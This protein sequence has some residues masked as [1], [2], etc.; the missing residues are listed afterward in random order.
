[1]DGVDHVDDGGGHLT[2][3]G[4][5][6]ACGDGV[7]DALVDGSRAHVEGG[8]L[9]GTLL[10]VGDEL[11]GAVDGAP[12]VVVDEGLLHGAVGVLAVHDVLHGIGGRGTL[13]G[14]ARAL[15][16]DV[17]VAKGV[18]GG[19]LQ[20]NNG[21]SRGGEDDL[22]VVLGITAGQRQIQLGE[23]HAGRGVKL[24]KAQGHGDGVGTRVVHAARQLFL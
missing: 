24:Q 15:N 1:M 19:D 9:V 7:V 11:F 14:A 17:E 13:E 20:V 16:L 23:G 8:A 4:Q 12:V 10:L 5:G 2:G 6:R 18:D 21:S 3:D 22:G